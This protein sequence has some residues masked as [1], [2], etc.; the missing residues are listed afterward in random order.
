MS[1]TRTIKIFLA[2]S[3]EMEIDRNAFGNLV[4]RLD[5]IY[6]K[7]GIRIE[8]FEWEDY[9]AAYN[10]QRKQGEYNEKVRASDMFLALFHTKAGK[11]T[12]EEF[13]VATEEFRHTGI[14]PKSYVYMRDI[15]PGEEESAELA[16]FKKRLFEEM[17]HYWS[18]YN[19]RDSM[20]LH[21]VMQLQLV[22]NNS[23]ALKVENGEVRFGD[24]TVARMEN[25]PF[26]AGNEDYQR[27]SRRLQELPVLIEKARLR[28]EKYPDD[29]DLR[30][31]LQKHLDERNAMQEDFD[32]QQ[33]LLFDT[34]KRI[35]QLQGECINDRMRRAIE[36]F[37][38][39]NVREANIILDEAE[40]DAERNMTDYRNSKEITEQKRQNVIN[41]IEE[42]LLKTATCMADVSMPIN[43]RIY[44]TRALYFQAESMAQE[45][46][47]DKEKYAKLLYDYALFLY[48]YAFYEESLD[49]IQK[50]IVLTS[51]NA[52]SYNL[53]GN[54]Y[55]RLD[56]YQESLKLFN[57][58]LELL[59]K[60]KTPNEYLLAE[61]YNNIGHLLNR[62]GEANEAIEYSRKVLN[63]EG[64]GLQGQGT[65]N[66]KAF[67]NIAVGFWSQGCYKKA[68]ES[69]EK[70]LEIEKRLS[71][72]TSTQ[73]AILYR[74][75]GEAYRGLSNYE[76]ALKY[77][78][79]ALSILKQTIGDRHPETAL[80]YG[81]IG[82]AY[83]EL[84]NYKEAIYN[85]DKGLKIREETLGRDNTSTAESYYWLGEIYS[86]Q[87]EYQDYNKALEYYSKAETIRKKK[88]G[89]SH[90]ETLGVEYSIADLYIS[91]G[92]YSKAIDYFKQYLDVLNKQEKKNNSIIVS[93]SSSL[94]FLY[95]EI[96]E[97]YRAIDCLESAIANDSCEDYELGCTHMIVASYY[98][99]LGELTK[100]INHC[101]SALNILRKINGDEGYEVAFLYNLIAT[102]YNEIKQYD[103]A[104]S[105]NKIALEIQKRS[106][107]TDYFSVAD[108]FN[109][110]AH[111]CSGR[112][113]YS[114]SICYYQK[115]MEEWMREPERNLDNIL[116]CRIEILKL[117][118]RSQDTN[119][120]DIAKDYEVIGNIYNNIGCYD[121]S[122]QHLYKSKE[123]REKYWGK[124]N[125]ATASSYKS[126][127]DTYNT[128]GYYISALEFYNEALIIYKEKEGEGSTNTQYLKEIIGKINKIEEKKGQG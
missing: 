67:D 11:F 125:V 71:G 10:N 52:Q 92:E 44:K 88:Y 30:D 82:V 119:P 87:S 62:I 32:K 61:T 60:E 23:D 68:L 106:I 51:A 94:G 96:G 73:T 76:K 65:G 101:G 91:I 37:D 75:I 38:S 6:E 121:E 39:G 104:L 112:G 64:A 118:E 122:I 9:D 110:M 55:Y 74:Q 117:R 12:I 40:K 109:S 107:D 108:I 34:A 16:A 124:N 31:E 103:F 105:Y 58:A 93:A 127:G 22:E 29:D 21:F 14:K 13:N 84:H 7:R 79:K 57:K 90:H 15:Q 59:L 4:R 26:A 102:L 83:M 48:D 97:Y 116:D 78:N 72:D 100:A 80:T 5:N 50:Q 98:K 86:K 120:E 17:G 123:I 1:T 24:M 95:W 111:T 47:Y 42:L 19:N 85:T 53:Q 49:V 69:T 54:I 8:L 25:L 115:A 35:A 2:S 27:M 41:S 56:Q 33:E 114:E 89:E 113:D 28:T 77:Y 99:Y 126:I 18:R 36:A 43:E 20:Q 45:I 63:I 128:Y 81:C 66:A 46:G 3:E 70:A